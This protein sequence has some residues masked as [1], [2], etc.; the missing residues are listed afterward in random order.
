MKFLVMVKELPGG[1]APEDAME[2]NRRV[3]AWVSA[4]LEAGIVE[5]A[6]YMLPKSGMCIINTASHEQLLSLLRQWP[7]YEFSE[8]DVRPLAEL[9]HGIDD[10]YER[11]ARKAQST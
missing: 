9:R 6:Y 2:L 1:P 11:M 5:V 4:Q 10:N 3:A 7:A 8:F